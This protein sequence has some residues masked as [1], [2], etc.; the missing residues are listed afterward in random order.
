MLKLEAESGLSLESEVMVKF[1]DFIETGQ[2]DKLDDLLDQIEFH[3]LSIPVLFWFT[4]G[5]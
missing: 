5:I 4:K 2:W 3:N 1:R